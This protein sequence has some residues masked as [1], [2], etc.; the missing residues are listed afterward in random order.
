MN[1]LE[2]ALLAG[3]IMRD[4]LLLNGIV[5]CGG[6]YRGFGP[7]KMR[8]LAEHNAPLLP[9]LTNLNKVSDNLTAEL[10]LKTIGAERF[11][12]P[13]SAQKGARAIKLF[14]HSVG[15]DTL[16]LKSVDGSGLSRYNLLTPGGVLEL[17]R[18]IWQ[19]EEWRNAF[20]STLPI[21]GVDGTL[22][23]RMKGTS[24]EG[25]L[26]AKTGSLSGVSALSGYTVTAEGEE[27]VFAMMMQHY[28]VRDAAVRGLQDR[29]GAELCSFRRKPLAASTGR[30]AN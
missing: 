8:V 20:A 4:V 22:R 16:A 3:H 10:V 28:L 6:V 2:P 7:S 25:V 15:V 17:L 30:R 13:G 24:A 29:I 5:V 26:R 19:H 21:A 14:L 18:A 1:V 23:N 12:R 11:G 27:L 9:A